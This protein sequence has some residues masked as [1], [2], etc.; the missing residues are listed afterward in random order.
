MHNSPVF[1]LR[2]GLALAAALVLLGV[3]TE[4]NTTSLYE[5]ADL[6]NCNGRLRVGSCSSRPRTGGRRTP[7]L[8]NRRSSS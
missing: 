2:I 5:T 8:I 4:I 1:P 3:P 7:P 6:S